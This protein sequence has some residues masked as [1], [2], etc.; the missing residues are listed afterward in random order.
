LKKLFLFGA[1]ESE[2]SANAF[3][4]L[5]KLKTWGC[6]MIVKRAEIIWRN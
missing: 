1:Q 5:T 3:Q 4:G 6:I 2:I